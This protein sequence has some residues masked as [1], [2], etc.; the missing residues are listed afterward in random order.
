M[1]DEALTSLGKKVPDMMDYSNKNK[2]ID[3]S[4]DLN[5]QLYKL[6]DLTDEE[7]AYIESVVG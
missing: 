5:E 2:L 3:F 4:K 1:T 6:V 7:V